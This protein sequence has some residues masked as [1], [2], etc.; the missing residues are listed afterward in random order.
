[1]FPIQYIYIYICYLLLF[2]G[3]YIYICE[4]SQQPIRSICSYQCDNCSACRPREHFHAR[5]KRFVPVRALGR[6]SATK[7]VAEPGFRCG[8]PR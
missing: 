7:L 5:G 3:V 2:G 6:A 1:M 8:H 4:F